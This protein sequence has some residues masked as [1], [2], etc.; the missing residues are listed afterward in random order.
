MLFVMSFSNSFNLNW[1]DIYTFYN[2]IFNHEVDF[3]MFIGLQIF[4]FVQYMKSM[5]RSP[6]PTPPT[7]HISQ[8]TQLHPLIPKPTQHHPLDLDP[9]PPPGSSVLQWGATVFV[10]YSSVH[11]KLPCINVSS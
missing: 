6:D 10:C 1:L 3:E 7:L 5:G 9:T 11:R 2:H 4:I 8:S